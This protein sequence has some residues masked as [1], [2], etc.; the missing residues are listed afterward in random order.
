MSG[1][2]ALLGPRRS[3]TSGA[4]TRTVGLTDVV[5][6]LDRANFARVVQALRI[7][8]GRFAWDL[9]DVAATGPLDGELA[10]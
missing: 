4:A 8:R 10:A 3:P 1:G 5:S 2:E 9:V 6:R 7:S